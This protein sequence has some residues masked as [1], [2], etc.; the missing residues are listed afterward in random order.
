MVLPI[1]ECPD[2][3]DLIPRC[4]QRSVHLIDVQIDLERG[5]VVLVV[6]EARLG[7]GVCG[8]VPP[9]RPRVL[10]VALVDENDPWRDSPVTVSREALEDRGDPLLRLFDEEDVAAVLSK[11]FCER[12]QDGA[13]VGR[14]LLLL[15]C[16]AALIEDP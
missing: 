8:F 13:R 3:S 15:P 7:E 14:G 5:A 2:P 4:R 6:L 1:Q 10:A 12:L 9:L 16:D 11:M